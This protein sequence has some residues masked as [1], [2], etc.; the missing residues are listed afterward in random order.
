[1]RKIKRKIKVAEFTSL[2][3]VFLLPLIMIISFLF[4]DNYQSYNSITIAI[5]GLV[6]FELSMYIRMDK[7]KRKLRRIR[8][9]Y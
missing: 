9:R 2:L 3:G 4:E 7:L 1:M 8:A 6:I 5:M